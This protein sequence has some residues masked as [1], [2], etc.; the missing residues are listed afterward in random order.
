MGVYSCPDVVIE[1]ADGNR[2]QPLTIALETSVL[3]GELQLSPE[4][5]AFGYFTVD[6]LDRIDLMQHAKE[7]IDDALDDE[8]AAFI[9]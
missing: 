7:R 4:T 2:Y 1:Y 8:D 6:A 3:G 9:R 5:T